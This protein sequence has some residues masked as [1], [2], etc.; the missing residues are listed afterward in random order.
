M[1]EGKQ[2]KPAFE[3]AGH[4][5]G[6]GER[7]RFD[8][9]GAQLYTHTPLDMPVEV[10]NGRRTGCRRR[11]V[12]A[13]RRRIGRLQTTVFGEQLLPRLHARRVDRDAGHRAQLHALRLVDEHAHT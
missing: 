12:A 13:R 11:L 10:V 7:V 8:L 9:P 2:R 4:T 3:I 6:P 1:G 5:V